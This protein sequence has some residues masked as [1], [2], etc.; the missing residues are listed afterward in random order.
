M[1]YIWQF[2]VISCQLSIIIF[3]LLLLLWEGR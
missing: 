3:L 1:N 2:F